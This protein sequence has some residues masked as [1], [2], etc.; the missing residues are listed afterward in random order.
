MAWHGWWSVVDRRLWTGGNPAAASYGALACLRGRQREGPHDLRRGKLLLQTQDHH[1]QRHAHHLG[2][3]HTL[4]VRDI[5][6][7]VIHNIRIIESTTLAFLYFIFFRQAPAD[8]VQIKLKATSLP[9]V[10]RV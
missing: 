7:V 3:P 8:R 6:H 10:C 9:H 1:G 5:V 4:Q 2:L